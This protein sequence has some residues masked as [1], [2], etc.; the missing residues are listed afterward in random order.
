MQH[1]TASDD[2][3][4]ADEVNGDVYTPSKTI[5]FSD[6]SGKEKDLEIVTDALDNKDKVLIVDDWSETG[7]QLKAV[8]SLVKQFDAKIVGIS[9]INI[10]KQ[11]RADSVLKKY[12]LHSIL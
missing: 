6:Y 1:N 3:C 7:A 10:D 5:T 11:A 12:K 4:P 9:C 2:H 8:I